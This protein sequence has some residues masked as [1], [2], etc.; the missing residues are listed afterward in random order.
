MSN[1]DYSDLWVL[2]IQLI[3]D[4]EPVLVNVEGSIFMPFQ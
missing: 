1:V 2:L 3:K 4:D